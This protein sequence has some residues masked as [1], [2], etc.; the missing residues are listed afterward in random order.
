[1][2]TL[3]L[4]VFMVIYKIYGCCYL[5][6]TKMYMD[7]DEYVKSVDMPSASTELTE[8]DPAP[9]ESGSSWA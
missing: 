5:K 1:M 6:A 8:S 2:Y 9:K 3:I 7:Y 4:N